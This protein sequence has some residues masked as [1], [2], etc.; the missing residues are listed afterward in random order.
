MMLTV[1]EF[2]YNLWTTEEN[3][4]KRYWVRIKATGEVTEVDQEVMRVLRCEEKRLV[5]EIETQTE[6]GTVLSLDYASEDEVAEHW[7]TDPYQLSE[8]VATNL[9]ERDFEKLLTPFQR[10]IYHCCMKNGMKCSRYAKLHCLDSS[11]VYEAREAVRKKFKKY[12]C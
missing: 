11:T 5:R 6:E 8:D 9:L 4:K 3:G 2:D 1:K 12:F 7:L 10:E